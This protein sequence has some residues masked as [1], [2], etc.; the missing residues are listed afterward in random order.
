MELQYERRALQD[1]R[2]HISSPRF[3]FVDGEW[4]IVRIN[5]RTSED[6]RSEEAAID[7]NKI[8]GLLRQINAGLVKLS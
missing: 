7:E 1:R 8:I 2:N 6:R 5:R 4:N 3:P